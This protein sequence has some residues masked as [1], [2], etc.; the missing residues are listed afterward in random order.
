MNWLSFL[1]PGRQPRREAWPLERLEEH[2][3]FACD[4][5]IDASTRATYASGMR[6][7]LYFCT[8]HGFP[9]KPTVDSISFYIVWS[10]AQGIA[11]KSVEGYLSGVYWYW[12][13]F[14][15]DVREIQKHQYVSRT[16]AGCHKTY[17][18]PTSRKRPL[19][20]SDLFLLRARLDLNSYDD[21]LFWTITTVAWHS[22]HRLGELVDPD[23][24]KLQNARKRILR[25]SIISTESY[26][27]YTLP[28]HKTDRLFSGNTCMIESQSSSLCAKK[29]LHAYLA[30]RDSIHPQRSQLFLASNGLPPR[31]SWYIRRLRE[32]F[33]TSISGHSL[34]SGGATYLAKQGI[35]SNTIR[36]LGRWSS[37]AFEIYIRDHPILIFTAAASRS[38]YS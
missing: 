33:D 15:P 16:L 23:S 21:L 17:S 24:V 10:C 18:L 20:R 37:N 22:L 2:R 26:I 35:D 30:V 12:E 19:L 6:S 5:S 28:Y 34:R 3:L 9:E 29:A 8:I 14:E 36:L 38:L 13:I 11:P 25:S 1:G 32:H 27:S 4:N 31:R 7:Y